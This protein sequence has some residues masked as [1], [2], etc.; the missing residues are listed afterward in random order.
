MAPRSSL[1]QHT[2]IKLRKLYILALTAIALSVII[3]QLFIGKFLEEQEG[4]SKLINISGRQR[5]LSQKLTKESLL[6]SETENIEKRESLAESLE[7]SLKRWVHSHEVFQ[8]G[9]DSLNIAS[10]KSPEIQQK[11]IEIQPY[12]EAIEEASKSLLL[13]IEEN[14]GRPT[15]DFSS[16]IAQILENEASFLELMDAMVNQ[17]DEEAHTRVERLQSLELFLTIFTL[18]ILLLEFFFIFLPA[19]KGV[20]NNIKNLIHAE[21]RAV[22]MARDADAISEAREKSVKE[23]RALGQAMDKILLFARITPNGDI[24]HIGERFSK[25]FQY[26]KFNMETK[27]SEILSPKENEQLNIEKLISAHKR[28]GWQGEVKASTKDKKDIWLEL[29]IVPFQPEK[30]K[31]E[32]TIIGVDITKNKE[33]Q[34]KIEELTRKSYEEKMRQHGLIAKKIIENQENE[35]NRIAKDIHD[36]IGQMLTGLKYNL[37]SID[38]KYPEKAESKIESLKELSTRI[39]QG[40]R[41]AT[42]NLTPPELTDHGIVPALQKLTEELSKL[43]GKDIILFNKTGFSQRLGN[44]TEI[45]LYRITQEAVNNAIKYAGSTHI[46]VSVSHSKEILSIGIEDNGKGFDPKSISEEKNGNR[47]MGLTFMKERVKFINGRLFINSSPGEGTRVTLNFP[48]E[49]D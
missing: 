16:E 36:G 48:L 42:F 9:S 43:T 17:Y 28:S 2:F 40:V 34:L 29:S 5:M 30:E 41:A 39:I 31:T 11:F 3:S 38:F 7:M 46:I 14:P 8:N 4:D 45:N 26:K 24:L 47:G 18:S 37:E 21:S 27:F 10:E 1:D 22:K 49:Q 19:A 20:K 6:L 35:Q 32:L 15:E 25:L 23:L 13:K 44:I 12:F 33:A